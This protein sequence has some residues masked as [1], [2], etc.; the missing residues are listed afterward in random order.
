MWR[1]TT[2]ILQTRHTPTPSGFP[3]HSGPLRGSVCW[4]PDRSS[5]YH[6]GAAYKHY[7]RSIPRRG[8]LHVRK[9]SVSPSRLRHIQVLLVSLLCVPSHCSGIVVKE[10]IYTIVT[11]IYYSHPF[12]GL[13]GGVS[14]G[15]GL[16]RHSQHQVPLNSMS[17]FTLDNTSR[18]T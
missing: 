12:L 4:S 11:S 5:T 7:A 10:R 16:V 8:N 9:T 15:E 3:A 1:T 2:E 14:S 18:F 6:E 13:E 17:T